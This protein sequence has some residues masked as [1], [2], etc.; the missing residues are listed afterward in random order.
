FL[1]GGILGRILPRD[2]P[3]T[4]HVPMTEAGAGS[5]PARAPCSP[6]APL[7]P[8]GARISRHSPGGFAAAPHASPPSELV[9]EL[10][11]GGARIS[12]HSPAPRLRSPL[13]Q[14]GAQIRN[15]GRFHI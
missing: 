11:Q 1:T 3:C 10:V 7:I 12:R 2:R 5:L 14:G 4:V 9:S 13:D 15:R 6:G 8:G